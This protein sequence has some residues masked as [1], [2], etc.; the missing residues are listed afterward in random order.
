MRIEPTVPS[1][2]F[3]HSAGRALV[4]PMSMRAESLTPI[5]QES[6][7]VN[8]M[9]GKAPQ[10]A[11]QC[12][13]GRAQPA[14]EAKACCSVCGSESVVCDEVVGEQVLQLGECLHCEYRWTWPGGAL[15]AVAVSDP[16]KAGGRRAIEGVRLPP[17]VP[18]AA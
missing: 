11:A 5:H 6:P 7:E 9:R 1:S 14:P 3:A 12:S 16:G 2:L 17:K 8:I 13:R 10:K 4:T 15:L 18:S